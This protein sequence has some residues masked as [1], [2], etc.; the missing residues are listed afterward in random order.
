MFKRS[1]ATVLWFFATWC[2]Y[3]L[4]VYFVGAP[5]L[6]GPVLATAASA[7]IGLDPMR[8]IWRHDEPAPRQARET[9][10]LHG[11]GLVR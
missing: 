11:A 8:A 10:Q 5:R 1:V 7:L 2:M 3:E 4:V 9:I 6:L